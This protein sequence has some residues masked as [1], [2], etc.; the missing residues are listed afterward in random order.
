M[1]ALRERVDAVV[2]GA[3]NLRAD[4][5]DLMPNPLRVVVTRA[6]DRIPPTAKMFHKDLGGEAVVAHTAMMSKETRA[7]L[8]PHATLVELGASNVDILRLI[9]WLFRERGCTTLV[10]EGGGVVAAD[11]FAARAVDELHLT[12]VSRVLGGASA[13]T[14][15]EGTGFEPDAI[16]DGQLQSVERVG[17]ELY[18]VYTFPW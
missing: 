12:I 15:V 14:C 18:L 13:P 8:E 4:D 5:P 16:P 2:I 3:A 10:C 17:D 7:A 11:F 1:L 6:G 9:D